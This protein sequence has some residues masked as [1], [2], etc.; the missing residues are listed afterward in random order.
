MVAQW[1]SV[2]RL[3]LSCLVVESSVKLPVPVRQAPVL[4]DRDRKTIIMPLKQGV[5]RWWRGSQSG[6]MVFVNDADALGIKASP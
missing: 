3:L 6:P 1:C 4:V 2:V 5:G